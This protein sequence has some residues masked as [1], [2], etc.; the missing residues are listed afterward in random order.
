MQSLPFTSFQTPTKKTFPPHYSPHNDSPPHHQKHSLPKSEFT[1]RDYGKAKGL[2]ILTF[3]DSE[4]ERTYASQTSFIAAGAL[5]VIYFE[6]YNRFIISIN[7]W[8]YVLLRRMPVV[9]SDTRLPGPVTYTLPTCDG[10]YTLRLIS[11]DNLASVKN[12]ETILANS[13]KFSSK[14]SVNNS[15]RRI[16]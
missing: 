13:S 6:A 9:G 5:H 3:K 15:S 16:S 11:V 2:E 12:F 7:D 10:F 4:L 14:E 8:R 1:Q